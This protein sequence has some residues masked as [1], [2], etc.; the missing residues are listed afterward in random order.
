VVEERGV[1]VV[2][3][4]VF[5]KPEP[6]GSKRAFVVAGKAQVVDANAKAKPWKEQ[7]AQ[8][9]GEH[10]SGELLDGPLGVR[11]VFYQPRP[12]G[13]Y[14]T[15]RNSSWLKPAAPLYPTTRPDAL[16]L[17]RAVEDALS[18]VLYRD[19]SQIVDERLMKLYG[20]PARCVVTVWELESKPEL[21][22]AA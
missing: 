9:A 8:V 16:K 17:A 18:G 7:V 2:E 15:G 12:K 19:D 3:F 13:H 10:F 14:G 20:A 6:A 4:T 5:G 21:A 11:F 22:V 1:S